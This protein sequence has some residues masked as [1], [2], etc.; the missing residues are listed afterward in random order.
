MKKKSVFAENFK[1]AALAFLITL[2]LNCRICVVSGIETE[3]FFVYWISKLTRAFSPVGPTELIVYAAIFALLRYVSCRVP[4]RDGWALALSGLFALLYVVSLSFRELDSFEYLTENRFQ[5]SVSLLVFSGIWALLYPLLKLAFQAAAV[6]SP[7][8]AAAERGGKRLWLFGFLLILACYIPWTLSNYPGTFFPDSRWQLEQFF[9][10]KPWTGHHPPL[11]TAVMGI[12]VSLGT[13]LGSPNFGAYLYCLLQAVLGAAVFSY[14][15]KKMHELGVSRKLCVAALLFY[16]L[17]P[18]WGAYVQSFE[19][20]L[21]YTI[22]AALDLLLLMDIVRNR[23]CSGRDI[24]RVTAVTL[25]AAL[26]RNNGIYEL[27]PVLIALAFYLRGIDRKRC[28]AGLCALLAIY[29]GVTKALYPAVGIEPGSI[30]EAL[31]I[32]F[33]Q[34]ARYVVA[35]GDEVTDYE[36]E[37]I[38]SVIMYDEIPDAYKPTLSDPVKDT[39]RGDNS[40]LPEYF[41]VWLQMFFKHPLAYFG[42]FFNKCYGT[43]APVLIS[44]GTGVSLDYDPYLA[45]LGIYR[46]HDYMPTQLFEVLNEVDMSVPVLRYICVP[47]LY[48]WLLLSCIVL[49]LKRK[50]YPALILLIPGLMNVLICVAS[51]MV[52]SFRYEMPLIATMPVLLGWTCISAGGKNAQSAPAA[53][54]N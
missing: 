28:I 42:A 2:A 41:K 3:S 21:L 7:D 5:M 19:K 51:P 54:E 44:K 29:G 53:A 25:A 36:R 20:S 49:L 10:A 30:R 23:R 16:A 52:G 18:M 33:Q 24:L 8:G 48:T 47:G 11:S 15:V 32:P 43:I 1:W 50:K 6:C 26:L 46:V 9:G 31:S 39:Y 37:V 34:T 14:G 13:A 40:K 38:D 22:V 17:P 35:Y 12:L 4:E 45:E 27:L